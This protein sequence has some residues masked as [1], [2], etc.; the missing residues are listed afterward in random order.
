M[1]ILSYPD[2]KVYCKGKEIL[3]SKSGESKLILTLY[4]KTI[5]H[6]LS[7]KLDQKLMPKKSAYDTVVIIIDN[8]NSISFSVK[9]QVQKSNFVISRNKIQRIGREVHFYLDGSIDKAAIARLAEYDEKVQN[10]VLRLPGL[11][12]KIASIRTSANFQSF[13]YIVLQILE[14]SLV[15]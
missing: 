6:H 4:L 12:Y 14:N 8:G 13:Y 2:Y 11:I 3:L 10:A 15:S 7:S 5:I 9:L 1:C